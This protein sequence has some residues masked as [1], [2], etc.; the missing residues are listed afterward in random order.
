MRRNAVLQISALEHNTRTRGLLGPAPFFEVT[1]LDSVEQ[2]NSAQPPQSTVSG[3]VRFSQQRSYL[4]D[5]PSYDTRAQ[6]H[7]N[8]A[9]IAAQRRTWHQLALRVHWRGR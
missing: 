3:G 9:Q 7:G 6:C 4:T 1:S 5:A 2:N 8:L